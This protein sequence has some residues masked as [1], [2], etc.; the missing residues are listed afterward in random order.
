MR[1]ATAGET[2]IFGTQ[3][4]RESVGRRVLQRAP[5]D[6]QVRERPI[7]LGEC[8]TPGF[9]ELG[10]FGEA[11]AAQTLR[12]RADRM[13]ARE[14]QAR[15]PALQHL[16]QTRL[17]ERRFGVGRTREPSDAA[18]H[19][20]SHLAL[21][22]R[23]VLEAGFAQPR[24][25]VHETRGDHEAVRIDGALGGET[26]GRCPHGCDGLADDEEIGLALGPGDRVHQEAVGDVQV[27][28]FPARMAITAMRTAMPN[29]TC[30]RITD[31]PPSATAE[32]IST[33]R[34]MGPGCITIASFAATASRSSVRP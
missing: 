23:A 13:H 29:V 10:H 31:W 19:C 30:G 22:R 27:H 12:E 32:S 2:R 21:E 8:D 16:H 24:R 11:L 14:A 17:V 28:P 26:G 1:D 6:G 33:P 5:Q 3:P 25:Q 18:G 7:V 15:R 20:R 4:H 34:F 9:G